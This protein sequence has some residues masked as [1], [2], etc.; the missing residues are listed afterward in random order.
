[1]A[2]KVL[3]VEDQF[4]EADSLS[5]ILKNGGYE[6]HGIA[7]S[8]D[9]ATKL[10]DKSKPDIVLVDIFLKGKL[11]GID[12]ARQLDKKNIPF[13]FLSAN[14]NAITMEEA[15]A[16]KPFGFLIKPFREREILMTLTIAIYRHQKG[17]EFSL[18]Q[19]HWLSQ[20]L[21]DITAMNGTQTEKIL[22]LVKALT[23]FMPFDFIVIDTDVNNP[24]ENAVYK[25]Q[26]I[27]FDEYARYDAA[28]KPD[29]YHQ[30]WPDLASVRKKNREKRTPFYLNDIDYT[31]YCK[32]H[33]IEEKNQADKKFQIDVVGALVET[34]GSRY[35]D[36]FLLL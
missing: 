19:H 3:I 6:I 5:I 28:P 27:G 18:R 15:L 31:D 10:I 24:D 8:V 22:A 4:V 21:Q 9:E 20:L 14:S 23:S 33:A 30:Q 17:V 1:M 13:V 32:S 29:H 7:K 2:L 34:L 26:R 35:V 12:L 36:H 11:T 16:T 25:Y